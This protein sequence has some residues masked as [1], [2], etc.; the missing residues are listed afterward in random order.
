MRRRPA[1]FKVRALVARSRRCAI[2]G[3]SRR[4]SGEHW[5]GISNHDRRLRKMEVRNR[6]RLGAIEACGTSADED[7]R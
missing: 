2:I 5:S 6:L 1:T 7:A 3:N 4:H